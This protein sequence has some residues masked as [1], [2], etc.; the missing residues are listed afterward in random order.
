MWWPAAPPPPPPPP[1]SL[2]E[3]DIHRYVCF[4]LLASAVPTFVAL[5]TGARAPYGRYAGDKIFGSLTIPGRIDWWG[6]AT[7]LAALMRA[8]QRGGAHAGNPANA[9]LLAL[10]GCHYVWRSFIFSAM[11]RDPKPCAVLLVAMTSGFCLLNGW[12]QAR[13]LCAYDDVGEIT[14]RFVL[15][16]AIFLCGWATNVS[17]DLT[18]I[19]LRKPGETGYKIPRGGLFEYVSGANFFGEILEWTGFAVAAGGT[20]STTTFAVFTACNIG[21]RAVTHHKWYL[22]KFGSD[23]PRQRRALIPF[24]W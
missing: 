14:A 1:P 18:L 20:L 19:R 2:T 3:E 12:L 13:A 10:F 22:T 17:S 24:V 21:P 23:Y 15:G 16:V 11:L 8:I 5:L 4:G 7:S 9:I 6:H